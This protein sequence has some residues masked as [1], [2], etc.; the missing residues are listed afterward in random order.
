MQ[1]Y[2]GEYS[3]CIVCFSESSLTQKRHV[4]PQKVL[5]YARKKAQSFKLIS[6]IKE[7]RAMAK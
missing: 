6:A 2:S 4:I 1:N 5:E 7:Q 3:V